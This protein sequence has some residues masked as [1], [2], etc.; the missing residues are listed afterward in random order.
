MTIIGPCTYLAA[1]VTDDDQT[2]TS[3]M[4]SLAPDAAP[5]LCL[6]IQW[7]PEPQRI[8]QQCFGPAGEGTLA[9]NRFLPLFQSPG[10][11]G[12]GL[13]HRCV[14]RS[15]LQ[16]QRASD[17]SVTVCAPDS[18]MAVRIDGVPLDGS[19][20]LTADQV[21]RGAVLELGGLVV[22][23]LHWMRALPAPVQ[24]PAMLGVGSAALALRAQILQAARTDFPVLLLGETGTGKEVA[25]RAIHAA[26]ARRDKPWVAVNM[27]AMNEALAAAELFG[28][29]RGA[30]TGAQ[31]ARPGLF[32]EAADGTLFLD[33]IGDTPPTVQPMLLRV[34]E[35]GEYRP[36]G[37][38]GTLQSR[39]RLIA[40]TDRNLAERGFNQALLRRM[41]AFV[42]HLP[43]LR[44]RREDIGV[45]VLSVLR[46]WAAAH[47]GW[48]ALPA[49]LVAAMCRHDWPGNVRQ[50]LHT[51][52]R[53]L[54]A[55]D[56]RGAGNAA[57]AGVAGIWTLPDLPASV[58]PAAQA[59]EEAAPPGAPA[60]EGLAT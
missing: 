56:G 55:L 46:E 27:A 44:E 12:A 13:G 38:Q 50:L 30:Y 39:A 60:A 10:E 11:A 7:H 22:L 24:V 15:P 26:G 25:A 51:V 43:P 35:S 54:V 23:C 8:G 41:E 18:R 47:G 1:T 31:T 16:L 48:P 3:P 9:L 45:L 20:R 53:A 28:A 32:A 37:G 52:R 4:P 14:S 17:G 5:W 59:P 57:E 34:L 21:R 19:R 49:A 42:I 36:L 2:L 33:E 6:T 58:S 40:A 29:A